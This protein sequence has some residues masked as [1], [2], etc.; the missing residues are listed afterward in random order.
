MAATAGSGSAPGERIVGW[1][2]RHFDTKEGSAW[3]LFAFKALSNPDPSKP[4]SV[5]I[6]YSHGGHRA[7]K[8]VGIFSVADLT[9]ELDEDTLALLSS[10]APGEPLSPVR[11]KGRPPASK[12]PPRLALSWRDQLRPEPGAA[13]LLGSAPQLVYIT[14][15][16]HLVASAAAGAPSIREAPSPP[17]TACSGSGPRVPE[18][19]TPPTSA[20]PRRCC[21]PPSGYLR[22]PRRRSCSW[23]RRSVPPSLLRRRSRTRCSR[24]P[25]LEKRS[26]THSRLHAQARAVRPFRPLYSPLKLVRH[27]RWQQH[28]PHQRKQLQQH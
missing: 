8:V 21:F 4:R 10:G 23:T 24:A 13:T 19:S 16:G 12:K 7:E 26:L 17:F 25:T 1:V 9:I 28:H 6:E 2:A 18:C 14:Q 5:S 15:V 11:P 3:R 27:R 22:R 20:P